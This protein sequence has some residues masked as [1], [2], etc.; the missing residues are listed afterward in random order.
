MEND[1]YKERFIVEKIPILLKIEP[2]KSKVLW[3]EANVG[4]VVTLKIKF[5]EF[6]PN[7][8]NYPDHKSDKHLTSK[9]SLISK[10]MDPPPVEKH[11]A[12]KV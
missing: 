6:R 2:S 11:G 5:D 8:L 3:F 12:V 4:E 7:T 1:P 9:H 10:A